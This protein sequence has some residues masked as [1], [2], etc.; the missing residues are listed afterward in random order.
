MHKILVIGAGKI[1]SLITFLLA[2]SNHY[3]VYLADI[4]ETNPHVSRMG[5]QPNFKYVKLDASNPGMVADFLKKNKIDAIVSSLPYYCNVP[6]A[7]A[8]GRTSFA[9]FRSH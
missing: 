3:S 2:N 1:G 6:I 8:G 7:K 5:N 9:L 4:Q